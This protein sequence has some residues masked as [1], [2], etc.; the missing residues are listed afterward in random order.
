[1]K[2]TL[3]GLF[4]PL[5]PFFELID[6]KNRQWLHSFEMFGSVYEKF[7]MANGSAIFIGSAKA[8]HSFLVLFFL[9]NEN[10]TRQ[11]TSNTI[12]MLCKGNIQF[13][14]I[15]HLLEW[16]SLEIFWK[17]N[18]IYCDFWLCP[19][20]K[21]RSEAF[22]RVINCLK[23]SKHLGREHWFHVSQIFF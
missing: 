8:G 10:S 5:E 20:I 7:V 22:W 11:K 18:C 19:R 1:M 6:Y 23:S 3:N 21:Q 13:L 16:N 17:L 2:T 14:F 12:E 15:V 9:S 4:M